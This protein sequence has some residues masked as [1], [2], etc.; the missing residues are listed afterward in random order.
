MPRIISGRK[1]ATEQELLDFANAIRKAGGANVIQALLPSEQGDPNRCLIANA[2]NFSC[3]V[4]GLMATK[5]GDSFPENSEGD[6]PWFMTFPENMDT[7]RI[8]A[9]A[10][11]VPGARFAWGYDEDYA[12]TQEGGFELRY[13]R[14]PALRLPL[15]IGNA[16]HAF[17]DGDAFQEYVK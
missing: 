3:S 6:Y 13:T 15:H 7:D 4:G 14:V 2:L 17:D 5:D 11:I 10:K 1:V 12:T 8:R 16:A 9:I